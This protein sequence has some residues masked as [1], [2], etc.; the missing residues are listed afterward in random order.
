MSK[1]RQ[2]EVLGAKYYGYNVFWDLIPLCLGTWAVWDMF[3]RDGRFGDQTPLDSAQ[4]DGQEP[5]SISDQC[6]S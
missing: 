4:A 6:I 1:Y 3:Y 2:R 5:Q